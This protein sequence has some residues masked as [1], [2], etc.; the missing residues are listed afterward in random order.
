[1]STI[2]SDRIVYTRVIDEVLTEGRTARATIVSTGV[3]EGEVVTKT[4]VI[5]I[6]QPANMSEA[7]L[8][9][10]QTFVAGL[11]EVAAELESWLYVDPNP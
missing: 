1:M 9:T 5:N 8:T 11:D 3:K 2:T 4:S 10:F 7:E 6:T